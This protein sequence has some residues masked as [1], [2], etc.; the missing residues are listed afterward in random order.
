MPW[1]NT[2][3]QEL[4]WRFIAEWLRRKIPLA[5][6]CRR[7]AI[8][9]KTAYKWRARFLAR[10]RPGLV[11]A[12]RVAWRVHNR[13]GRVWL[14]RIRR[15]RARHPR[16]GA[17]KLRWVLGRRF[18]PRGLPSEAAIGRWLQRWGLSRQRRGRGRRGRPMARPALTSARQVHDVWTVDFKGWFRTGDGTR[19]DP[20]T[21]RDMASRYVVAVVLLQ[22]PNVEQ[23]RRA[24]ARI[25]G[26]HGLPR[27]IRTD[28]GSP[29][30]ADGALGLTRLSAW[31]VKL[32]IRVEFIEPGRPDQNGAHEQMHRV[33]KEETLQPPAATVRAQTL[34]SARW[35][36][37]YNHERPHEA[38]GMRVPAALYRKSRRK[39]P[40]KVGHWRYP[41]GWASRL[42][43]GKGMISLHG[44]SRFVGEAFE[45]ERV[46]LKKRSV[47]LWEVYFGPLRLGELAEQETGGIQALWYRRNPRH[48]AR[49]A[50]H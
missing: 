46:G 3:D 31:W 20:L 15:W 49:G 34:R 47:G 32:G 50:A 48:Q 36:Q 21:V 22:R 26:L 35:R 43:K 7:W 24:F 12:R 38:I 16:W 37:V 25:F 44:R 39:L 27:V 9:R 18:G 40:R 2:C 8:S 29:F 41:L 33:Y 10:G 30:G 28:N 6:Q 42:V 19:V 11:D 5:E 4:R 1:K 23:S 17:P 13:P 14:E 45:G